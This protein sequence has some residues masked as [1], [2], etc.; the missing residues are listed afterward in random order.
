MN[1][2]SDLTK[3][4]KDLDSNSNTDV[5]TKAPKSEKKEEKRS[6]NELGTQVAV[7]S[8]DQQYELMKML[9]TQ[10]CEINQV[11]LFYFSFVNDLRQ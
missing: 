2:L 8:A 3:V 5:S 4:L 7:P 1:K 10:I 6:D 9:Y 11:S